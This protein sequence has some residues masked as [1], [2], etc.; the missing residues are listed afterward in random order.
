VV[1]ANH[2]SYLDWLVLMSVLPPG[3]AFVAKRELAR[4]QP[5]RWL[6]E[7]AGTR[8][9]TRDDTHAAVEDAR[10]LSRAA[11]EGETLAFFPEGTF[12]R[13]PGLRPFHMGAFAVAAS[14]GL[15][16]VPVSLKGTRAVLRADSWCPR[17]RPVRVRVH[18]P[19]RSRGDDWHSGLQL[20][21]AARLSIASG[22]GEPVLEVPAA[23]AAASR[24]AP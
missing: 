8:F 17:R 7:R 6:L 9:V 20:R 2:A 19:L 11:R 18:A 23:G 4:R 3:T 21:D 16:V 5:L 1:V 12:T 10:A 24:P 14:A 13:A 15:P 22:C